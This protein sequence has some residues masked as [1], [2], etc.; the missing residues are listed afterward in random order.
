MNRYTLMFAGVVGAVYCGFLL[1]FA[2][3]K[4]LTEAWKRFCS[5]P[6]SAKVVAILAIVIASVQA[7]KSGGSGDGGGG[8]GD[9]GDGD[10]GTN[11][12]P[13]FAMGPA[14]GLHNLTPLAGGVKGLTERRLLTE[15]S[16]PR[17]LS[18]GTTPSLI[19]TEE[20]I[21]RGWRIDF[22]TNDVAH[23]YSMPTNSEYVSNVHIHGARS[24]FGLNRVDFGTWS[25]PLGPDTMQYG[26]FRF[27]LDGAIETPYSWST[28][29][30]VAGPGIG[31]ALAIPNFSRIWKVV[32]DDHSRILTWEN[33]CRGGDTN[34][35]DNYQIVLKE[36]GD[37]ETWSNE[38]GTVCR[39]INP[40]DWDD[41]GIPNG[42]DSNPT[43]SH[44]GTAGWSVDITAP[45]VVMANGTPGEITVSFNPPLDRYGES[46][47]TLRVN[48]G[49]GVFLR[50]STNGT[51]S[52]SIPHSFQP[53]E[54]MTF[55]VSS[56]I[57]S[58]TAD[59]VKFFVDATVGDD[60]CTVTQSLTIASV[61]RMEMTCP[62]AGQCLT[63]P[64]FPG[65]TESLF[66][67][68]TGAANS[69]HL[70]VPFGNVATITSNGFEVADFTITMSLALTPSGIDASGLE[71]EWE[72]AEAYP[73][74]SGS[75][76]HD[77]GLSARFVNPKQGGVFRFRGRAGGS[78]WTAGTAVLPMAGAS[79]DDVLDDDFGEA[80]I[81]VDLYCDSLCRYL[82]TPVWGFA[83]FYAFG[84]GDYRGR[85][86]CAT[87]RTVRCY[88]RITDDDHLGAVATVRGV[89]IRIAKL[90]NF[91][92]NYTITAAG[93]N[94][95]F[96]DV[97]TTFGTEDGPAARVSWSAGEDVANG[98]DFDEK[99]LWM[100]RTVW[101]IGDEKTNALWPNPS[102]TDNHTDSMYIYDYDEEF[103]SPV[104][105]EESRRR[106]ID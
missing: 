77:G 74:M 21:A 28:N 82:L 68:I 40:G 54:S 81:Y 59:N 53:G 44:Y 43:N 37:F 67:P 98:A 7:Q 60:S 71:C 80:G 66:S 49:D 58:S 39:R 100:V 102:E 27:T 14:G 57:A 99:I 17:L 106:S 104:F 6:R 3:R 101:S 38:V 42:R 18:A 48:G 33:I 69:Q 56:P 20:E 103:A 41:D 92:V 2:F 62:V 73:A 47:A 50:Q 36:G 75:F 31:D 93:V 4:P 83:N 51:D 10:G 16:S 52:I 89:P 45:K 11:N 88:N 13:M 63:P 96:R 15:G 32:A 12:A 30:I 90:S 23:S 65:E 19:V 1:W 24:R 8:D 55:Y 94:S 91:L 34:A 35:V 5:I 26:V 61:D 76:V 70:A 22:T 87:N 72:V 86:D 64:P 46:S 78:P 25:F 29:R 84:V 9:D 97:S 105:I 95:V 79:M 85:V